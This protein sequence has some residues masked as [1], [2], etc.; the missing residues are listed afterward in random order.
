MAATNQA[1]QRNL[2]HSDCHSHGEPGN[3]IVHSLPLSINER[4]LTDGSSLRSDEM[5]DTNSPLDYT[6]SAP[7]SDLTIILWSYYT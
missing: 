7:Q 4:S 1:R 5:S 6:S 3:F 2:F